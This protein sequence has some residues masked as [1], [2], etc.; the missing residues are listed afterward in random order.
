MF[1]KRQEED[2]GDR[3]TLFFG[4][5][6]SHLEW[7]I[8]A[9]SS[10]AR[11][12]VRPSFRRFLSIIS[13]HYVFCTKHGRNP[14]LLPMFRFLKPAKA[15]LATTPDDPLFPVMR[16]LLGKHSNQLKVIH[17]AS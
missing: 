6:H 17:R 2:H 15:L 12:S 8:H 11:T 1:R 14:G 3:L 7:T 5:T 16:Q 13:S 4:R 10:Y 9:I